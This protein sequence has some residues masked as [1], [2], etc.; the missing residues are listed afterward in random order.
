MPTGVW[1]PL[2]ISSYCFGKVMKWKWCGQISNPSW[3]TG[4]MKAKYYDQEFGLIKFISRR[5]DGIIRKAYI[6]SKGSLEI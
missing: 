3:P 1:R 5:K 6:D 4:F 2:F